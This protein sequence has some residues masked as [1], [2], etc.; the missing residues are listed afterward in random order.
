MMPC[1]FLA[2]SI[3]KSSLV[4]VCVCVCMLVE[5]DDGRMFHLPSSHAEE[6]KCHRALSLSVA[7]LIGEGIFNFG[8]LVS[9]LTDN[10]A[11]WSTHSFSRQL[12]QGILEGLKGSDKEWLIEL[13]QTFNEGN[14]QRFNELRPFWEQQVCSPSVAQWRS[15][16]GCRFFQV[17]LFA[18]Q[19]KL[20]DKI[21][22][23]SLMEVR[24][25]CC[26]SFLLLALTM[27]CFAWDLITPVGVQATRS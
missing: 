12:C 22:L 26:G 14:L 9:F 25:V 27:A 24:Y 2:A 11:Y 13:L 8:E 6:E 4:R 20:G 15:L 16:V 7:A 21:R 17:D 1:D 18:N 19:H 5:R 3:C 10:S 23:L